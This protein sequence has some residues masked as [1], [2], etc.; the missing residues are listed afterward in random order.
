MQ[1][2]WNWE[3]PLGGE[4]VEGRLKEEEGKWRRKERGRRQ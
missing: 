1:S 4:A 2:D 3:L